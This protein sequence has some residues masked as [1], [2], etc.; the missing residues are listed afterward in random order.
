MS[1]VMS[2]RVAMLT[3]P[4]DSRTPGARLSS[5]CTPAAASTFNSGSTLP[6]T[7]QRTTRPVTSTPLTP[8]TRDRSGTEPSKVA[9]TVSAERW[10]SCASVPTSTS[11]P[12]RRMATRSH[13][14]STSLRMCEDRNTVWPRSR[15]SST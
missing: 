8:G 6:C 13:S 15:D 1:Q 10:R 11:F 5:S 4:A 2:S 12:A 7:W 9:S 3:E 14:A